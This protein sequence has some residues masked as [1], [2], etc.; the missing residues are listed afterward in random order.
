MAGAARLAA[1]HNRGQEKK[2]ESK[3]DYHS[4]LPGKIEKEVRRSIGG[5]DTPPHT[6]G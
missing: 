5:D 3:G 1:D 2:H 4:G 6:A